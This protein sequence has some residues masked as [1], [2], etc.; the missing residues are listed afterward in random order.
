M[1]SPFLTLYFIVLKH[2]YGL[3][4]HTPGKGVLIVRLI[5]I[6]GVSHNTPQYGVNDFKLSWSPG[7]DTP[8]QVEDSTP[9]SVVKPYVNMTESL[10]RP[11]FILIGTV[12]VY[13][14]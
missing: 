14:P 8:E 3:S 11:D 1:P 7:G 5:I 9:V 12:R 4:H 6:L 2:L 13:P 10:F